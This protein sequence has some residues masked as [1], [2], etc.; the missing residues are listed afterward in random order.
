M[1][2]SPWAGLA[3]LGLVL[4]ACAPSV[5]GPSP[6]TPAGVDT[7]AIRRLATDLAA[8][9]MRGRGPFSPEATKAARRLAHELSALG[10]RPL[11]GTSLL[12]PFTHPQRPADTV[13]NVVG[14]LPPR[15]GSTNTT[16][17]G[18]TA[19]LDHLGVDA[20][21]ATGDSIYNGFL[22][23]AIGDAMIIDVARRFA[24][25]PGDRGLA[26][27]FFNLEEQGLL[28]S[29][30]LL[31]DTTSHPSLR[32]LALLIGVDA[33]A[34]AGEALDWEL[35]GALPAHPAA[36]LADSLAR[37]HGWTTRATPARG[38]S[39]V[40]PFARAGIPILFPIPG[41]HWR[42]YTQTGRDSAMATFDHYHQPSDRP[43]DDFP[44]V[45]TWYFAEWLWEIV[46][47]AAAPP[48]GVP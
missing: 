15:P 30:A 5:R 13:Y 35:M 42:G 48:R 37:A 22:D 32:R 17:I 31:R 36:L 44:M 25:H 9:S 41:P 28:G 23:D 21:D 14:Y 27:F 39:D 47:G 43:R 40:Y 24:A 6:A 38:I 26:V 20:P 16:L 18:L 4:S 29:L 19:H 11:I 10:A 45:G 2:H 1:R 34:P 33:G 7:V 46:Q 3:G 12:V 8:D